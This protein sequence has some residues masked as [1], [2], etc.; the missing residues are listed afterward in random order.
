MSPGI[1]YTFARVGLFLACAIPASLLLP[2]VLGELIKLLVALVVSS[3]L[4]F[5]LLRR[6]R[7]E[8]AEQLDRVSKKRVES[9]QRLRAALAGEDEPDPQGVRPRR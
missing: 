2:N 8:V 3:A 5:V 4:S 9:K 7:D 1:K 6:W